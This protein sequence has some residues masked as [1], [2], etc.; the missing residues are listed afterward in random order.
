[1]YRVSSKFKSV[2][3]YKKTLTT[4]AL[5]HKLYIL[6][7]TGLSPRGDQWRPAPHLKY[8]GK[9][10]LFQPHFF[11]E[12][13]GSCLKLKSLKKAQNELIRH[14]K[15]KHMKEQVLNTTSKAKTIDM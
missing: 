9:A 2:Y 13:R 3:Q 5:S 10:R 8:L 15:R 7:K 11:Q 14:N 1:V 6:S 4:T 12:M